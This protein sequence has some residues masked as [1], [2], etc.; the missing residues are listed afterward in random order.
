MAAVP[1]GGAVDAV[2]GASAAGASGTATTIPVVVVFVVFAGVVFVVH[3]LVVLTKFTA[4]IDQKEWRLGGWCYWRRRW[5]FQLS[6]GD[7]V[8]LEL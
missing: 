1:A 8:L 3:F 7:Q 6:V 5:G 2:T 4:V